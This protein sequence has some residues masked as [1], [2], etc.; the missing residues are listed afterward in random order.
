MEADLT[1]LT[2]HSK[3]FEGCA[4]FPKNEI[5]FDSKIVT[6]V[7][8]DALIKFL[9]SNNLKIDNSNVE[10][11]VIASDYLQID[12][13]LDLLIKYLHNQIMNLRWSDKFNTMRKSTILLYLRLYSIIRRHEIA[14]GYIYPIF[15]NNTLVNVMAN[16]LNMVLHEINLYQLDEERL[17]ELLVCDYLQLTEETVLKTIKLWINFDL[18]A[19]KGS[20]ERLVR[21]VRPDETITVLVNISLE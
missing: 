9:D 13:A 21:C 16:K 4:S 10:E 2:K 1:I 12:S 15:D 20:F 19:R 11:L 6:F 7:A 17:H 14:T 3:Y 18:E 5:I 8:L